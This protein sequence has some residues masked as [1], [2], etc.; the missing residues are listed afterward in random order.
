MNV[1]MFAAQYVANDSGVLVG[2]L[3]MALLIVAGVAVITVGAILY[4]KD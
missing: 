4:V 1:I 3:L 2:A